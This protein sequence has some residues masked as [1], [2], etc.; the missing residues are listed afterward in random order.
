MT[1]IWG[2][3][4]GHLEEAGKGDWIVLDSLGLFTL[5]HSS[6]EM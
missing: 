1:S 4:K 6:T 3:K 5:Y 2:I